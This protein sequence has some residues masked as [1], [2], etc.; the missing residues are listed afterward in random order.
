MLYW[1]KR[2][3]RTYSTRSK[4]TNF[5]RSGILSKTK[6]RYIALKHRKRISIEMSMEKS[7]K[8]LV[9]DLVP[10]SGRQSPEKYV[11][12]YQPFGRLTPFCRYWRKLYHLLTF[13]LA[14][15]LGNL[16]VD[17][18]LLLGLILSLSWQVSI[19]FLLADC[20]ASRQ[21]AWDHILGRASDLGIDYTHN[22]HTR[23]RIPLGIPWPFPYKTST[24]KSKGKKWKSWED[25]F[26][27]VFMCGQNP[28]IA[29]YHNSN[30]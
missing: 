28:K 30:M 7:S 16:C 29:E 21:N 24:A 2:L 14:P 23:M 15:I 6:C 8:C 20:F 19:Y 25:I 4:I 27:F 3:F 13:M 11:D 12:R 22:G 17:L 10:I 1:H 9:F 5:K 18:M 26:C